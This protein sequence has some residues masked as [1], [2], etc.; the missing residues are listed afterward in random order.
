MLDQVLCQ[1]LEKPCQ[2]NGLGLLML[3]QLLDLGLK[4]LERQDQATF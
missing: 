4:I 2:I 1:A 3:G